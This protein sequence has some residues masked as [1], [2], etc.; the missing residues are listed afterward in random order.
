MSN[1][2]EGISE[3]NRVS[4]M[5][6]IGS[7]VLSRGRI[8]DP[9]HM[10]HLF[11][12]L[13]SKHGPTPAGWVANAPTYRATK[14]MSTAISAKPGPKQPSGE[15]IPGVDKTWDYGMVAGNLRESGPFFAVALYVALFQISDGA[16]AILAMTKAGVET[17]WIEVFKILYPLAK[18][19]MG[20]VLS[21]K[22][23]RAAYILQLAGL[24]EG[25]DTVFGAAVHSLCKFEIVTAVLLALK[26]APYEQ[27]YNAVLYNMKYM[28]PA[29]NAIA[30]GLW[31]LV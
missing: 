4:G 20:A 3:D 29:G 2:F 19:Q 7:H 16:K 15:W 28:P 5:W 26:K 23:H 8:P 21:C 30:Y 24:G 1:P 6:A 25:C 14:A 18:Q 10:V 11:V 31:W 13:A 17:R 27:S 22:R 12:Y 9:M